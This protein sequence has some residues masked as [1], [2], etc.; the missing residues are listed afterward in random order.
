MTFPIC[1]SRNGLPLALVWSR[2]QLIC[3]FPKIR[4][5]KIFILT[6]S[7]LA[8]ICHVW[9]KQPS[10]NFTSRFER[11]CIHIMCFTQSYCIQRI[12]WRSRLHFAL[13]YYIL[14]FIFIICIDNLQLIVFNSSKYCII[15]SVI[16][17]INLFILILFIVVT[18]FLQG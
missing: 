3:R 5:K 6:F 14:I 4:R 16:F 1:S 8:L 13:R 9:R 11:E 18:W 10:T 15:T 7:F 12:L 17:I 2:Q